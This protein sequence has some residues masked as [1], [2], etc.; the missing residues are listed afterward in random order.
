MLDSIW[1]DFRE[2]EKTGRKIKLT[3]RKIGFF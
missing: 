1:E 2:E 3:D